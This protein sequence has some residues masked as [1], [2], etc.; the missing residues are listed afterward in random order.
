MTTKNVKAAMQCR[1][2]VLHW[3]RLLSPEAG[4]ANLRLTLHA[5]TTQKRCIM[6]GSRRE[7]YLPVLGCEF[8]Q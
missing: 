3:A 8:D 4:S 2:N 6:I 7:G 5:A 1:A